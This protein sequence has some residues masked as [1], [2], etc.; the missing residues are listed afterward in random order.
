MTR[1]AALTSNISAVLLGAFAAGDNFDAALRVWGSGSAVLART[2]AVLA[3]ANACLAIAN[4]WAVKQSIRIF[5]SD[6]YCA[7]FNLAEST[8][9]RP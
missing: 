1:A 5:A 4:A 6:A 2:F 3:L 7:G 9:G 8:R